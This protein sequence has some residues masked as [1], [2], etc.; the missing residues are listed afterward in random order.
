MLNERDYYRNFYNDVRR[1][2][3]FRRIWKNMSMT[4]KLITVNIG[5]YLLFNLLNIIAIGEFGCLLPNATFILN[6]WRLFTYQ[7]LHADFGHILGNMYAL[8]LFGRLTEHVLGPRRQLILYL[9]SG[10][11]GGLFW[12]MANFGT[13]GCL[14]GASGAVF[15][16]M[17]AAALAYPNAQF[18]LLIPPIPVK[19]WVLVLVYCGFEILSYGRIDNIAHLAHIGGAL[20]GL[21]FMRRLGFRIRL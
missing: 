21:I 13:N 11:I 6:P 4:G 7:F 16:V 19:L 2:P 17:T 18:M 12:V 3:D 9:S 1:G 20:G 14:L 8:W 5:V 15:G 10:L